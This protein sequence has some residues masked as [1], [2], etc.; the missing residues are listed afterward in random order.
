MR[1]PECGREIPEDALLCEYCGH[2]IKYVADYDSDLEIDA[3]LSVAMEVITDELDRQ[4][5]EEDEKQQKRERTRRRRKLAAAGFVGALIGISLVFALWRGIDYRRK[6]SLP[7]Y[8]GEAYR[9][10][11]EGDYAAAI[12]FIDKA[13]V[14]PG[15]DT[16][17]LTLRR[18]SYL[19]LADRKEE[20]KAVYRDIIANSSPEDGAYSEAYN[21][22]IRLYSSENDYE[23]AAELIGSCGD[24]AIKDRYSSYIISEPEFDVPG[25]SYEEPLHLSI[26]ATCGGS[27]FYTLNGEDPLESG[28]LY[29]GTIDLSEGIYDVRAV[30]VNLHGVHSSQVSARYEVEVKLPDAPVVLTDSGSY[31]K[32]T[33]IK[34]EKPETGRIVYTTDR[35]DPTAESREYHDPINMP[36]GTTVYRF[37]VVLPGGA[38]SEVVERTYELR[39]PSIITIEDG[40]NYILVEMIKAGEVVAVDGTIRD[41]SARFAYSYQG[42]R[43]IEGYGSFYI[44]HELL[45]DLTGTS[46][47]TGRK[48]AVNTQNA[49]VNIYEDDGFGHYSILPFTGG[50]H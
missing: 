22:L 3:E 29:K 39:L 33:L 8:V 38:V 1:C 49:I 50:D 12:A 44:Y 46:V 35:S 42:T 16:G 47:Q 45:V 48:F 7:Y 36:S 24:D 41:G 30:A 4:T 2:E 32:P 11:S 19:A 26:S 40:P 34:V 27:V 31:V 28:S 5:R 10:S 9:A 43:Q 18:A 23:S 17:T 15:V 37:A 6:H 21:E 25:G 20:A 13:I 14:M